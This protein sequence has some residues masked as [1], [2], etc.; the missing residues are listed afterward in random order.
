MKEM[1]P[2]DNRMPN[3][4]RKT[5]K[6]VKDLCNNLVHIE[7]CR[8]GCLLFFKEDANLDACKFYGHSRWKRQRSQQR[9]QN[10]L[11]YS[12][13]HCLPLKTST[14]EVGCIKKYFKAH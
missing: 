8:K 3:N 5:K 2:P 11:P 12:R 7:C 6:V 4:Y 13:M 14:P 9:D 10:P 1:C